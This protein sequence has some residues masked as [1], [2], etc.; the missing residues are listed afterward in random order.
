MKT[1]MN[2]PSVNDIKKINF[3]FEENHKGKTLNLN[4]EDLDISELPVFYRNKGIISP[5]HFHK[6]ESRSRDPE[7]LYVLRG[8]IKLIF[9][10]M[11]GEIL[12]MEFSAGEG[13]TCP[14]WIY[15]SYE[16]LEDS[17]FIEPRID[18]YED[19]PD[20]YDREEFIK[21]LNDK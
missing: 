8:K 7:I 10:D 9:E 6:G 13:Y 11:R 12:E 4:F 19:I 2:Y 17:I 18:K 20:T 1:Q 3:D 15:Q 16:I 5:G 14:P 21:I